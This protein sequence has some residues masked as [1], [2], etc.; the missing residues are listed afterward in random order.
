MRGS[1]RGG[2]V[3]IPSTEWP[4]I[5]RT[6]WP[7]IPG[8]EWPDILGTEWPDILSTEWPEIPS[9]EWPD[10]PGTEWPLSASGRIAV[11][12]QGGWSCCNINDDVAATHVVNQ[13]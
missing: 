5:P 13:L 4:V 3:G 12:F 11:W 7:G 9:T 8:T 6:E 10:I 1:Q 2:A